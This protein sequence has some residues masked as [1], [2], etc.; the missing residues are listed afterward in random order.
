LRDA[1]VVAGRSRRAEQGP[2]ERLRAGVPAR[3]PAN[4]RR[5]GGVT[6]YGSRSSRPAPGQPAGSGPRGSS[7][8]LA[9]RTNPLLWASATTSRR[10]NRD[11]PWTRRP[12]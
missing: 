2:H 10:I 8:P 6:S 1:P 5:P 11:R 3:G 12:R 9:E 4:D 7:C